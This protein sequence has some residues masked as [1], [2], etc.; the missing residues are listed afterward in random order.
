MSQTPGYAAAVQE[1]AIVLVFGDQ[2]KIITKDD[3]P[4]RFDLL[5]HA[6]EE[7]KPISDIQ[8]ILAHA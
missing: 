4:E 2:S 7:F 1:H 8:K 5:L 3:N 6:I